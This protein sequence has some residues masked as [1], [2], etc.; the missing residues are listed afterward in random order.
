MLR[1]TARSSLLSW[2]A[3]ARPDGGRFCY[4]CESYQN[5]TIDVQTPAEKRRKID[6]MME[7][8]DPAKFEAWHEAKY[9]DKQFG[10]LVMS[11][12]MLL[13]QSLFANVALC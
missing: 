12:V 9:S 4:R 13:L 1:F 6:E 3:R 10:R 2:L 11:N 7:L 8:K 5:H